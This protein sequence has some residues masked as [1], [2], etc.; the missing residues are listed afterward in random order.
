MGR[1]KKGGAPQSSSTPAA[2]TSAF[3]PASP[4]DRL[5]EHF[6]STTMAETSQATSTDPASSSSSTTAGAIS[7]ATT[8][9]TTA[10]T[11]EGGS[12]AQKESDPNVEKNIQ[13]LEEIQTELDKIKEQFV[14]ERKK[15]AEKYLSDMLPHLSKRRAIIQGN[16]EEAASNGV[17]G[18]WLK[19]LQQHGEITDYIEEWDEDVLQY[20]E[21]IE[22]SHLEDMNG[23]KLSFHFASNPYFK[24]SVLTKEIPINNMYDPAYASP[25]PT[26]IAGCDIEW[27][28]G[29]DVTVQQ[30]KKKGRK[31]KKGSNKSEKR[32]SFFRFFDQFTIENV[33]EME[34]DEAEELEYRLQS[35]V[36]IAMAIKDQVIPSAVKCYNGEMGDEDYEVEDEEEEDDDEAPTLEEDDEEDSS[37]EEGEEDVRE[38]IKAAFSQGSGNNDFSAI[39]NQFQ[40]QS[41]GANAQ[42]EQPP[43]CKQQ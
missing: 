25:D 28:P 33:Y 24:N 18:F 43:E 10:G 12:T 40:A 14:E 22:W 34:E 6:Q 42:E 39:A 16:H 9:L 26:R 8:T 41:S 4:F 2:P 15:L 29:K 13:K 21:D 5:A 23:F 37:D 17:P 27:C 31:G 7:N 36:D 11:G 35:D 38:A 1:K 3:T 20:L 19:A 32:E 30:K